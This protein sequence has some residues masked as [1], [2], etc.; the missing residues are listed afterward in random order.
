VKRFGSTLFV[1]VAAV[2]AFGQAG[3]SV[4]IVFA[5]E[6]DRE[7][8]IGPT[9]SP[10][11]FSTATSAQGTSIAMPVPDK[12]D[13]MT[14]YVHNK[15][16]GNVAAKPLGDIVTA[17]TWKVD[18]K[19]ETRV[20]KLTFNVTSGGK[21]V[22]SAV[23]K[24]KAGLETREALLSPADK[25]V[26]NIYNLPVGQVEVIVQYKGEA[27]NKT[28]PA[29]NFEAKLG[30]GPAKPK[31]I[32]ITDK[33]ET[34]ADEP[35]KVPESAATKGGDSNESS[36]ES[37]RSDKGRDEIP[38]PNPLVSFLN[39]LLGVAVIAAVCYGIYSY[40]KRN[41]KQV[42]DTLKK[43]GLAQ[44][45]PPVTD[46]PA[47]PPQPQPIKPIDLGGA[48]PSAAVVSPMGAPTTAVKNP[49]LVKSDGSVA[50][51]QEG[52]NI[53]GRD[54]GLA[55]SLAGESSVSRNH[56]RLDKAGDDVRI[57]DLGST[58]GTFVNG[59]KLSGETLLKP[60]DSVQFGAIAF[61]YEV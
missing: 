3:K 46:L 24:A 6:G 53:V 60:G 35:V 2:A 43:V 41:P 1:F 51:L 34:V 15:A 7:V 10:G 33:V 29:Q 61:R 32:V 59:A 50:L 18:P 55:I 36:R 57:T 44:M 26:A 12:P 4:S 21:A 17:G 48:P 31:S 14:V 5:G 56:A 49:R 30:A 11:D 58:N 40:V 25:G 42:E 9:A 13:G 8:W 38:A 19:D 52:S 27:G 39:L 23:V 45:D 54:E 47:T 28:T 20:F 16:T 37:A 22:A